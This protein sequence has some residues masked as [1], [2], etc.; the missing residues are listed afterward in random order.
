[1]M[2]K[3]GDFVSPRRHRVDVLIAQLMWPP[4]NA[5]IYAPDLSRR[6]HPRPPPLA[7]TD[8]NAFSSC[9]HLGNVCT[10]QRQSGLKSQPGCRALYVHSIAL[11][12]WAT[13][14]HRLTGQFS[15]PGILIILLTAGWLSNSTTAVRVLLM[16]LLSTDRLV[17]LAPRRR[18]GGSS[19]AHERSLSTAMVWQ[20]P[21]LCLSPDARWSRRIRAG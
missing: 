6:N 16:L 17:W 4:I 14:P 8:I 11:L 15:Q 10:G 2:K 20:N 3:T 1:M 9:P 7:P 5:A 21:C 12:F 13:I 19:V 18:P